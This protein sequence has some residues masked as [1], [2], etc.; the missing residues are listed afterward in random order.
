VGC[1]HA[2]VGADTEGRDTG[3]GESRVLLARLVL[4]LTLALIVAGIVLARLD[5]GVNASTDVGYLLTFSMFP[6]V[7][8]VLSSRRPDNTLGWIMAAIGVSL[9]LDALLST[10]GSY[11]VH[12]GVGGTDLGGAA[13]Q[14]DSVMWVPIVALPATF[15]ILLFP[16][17]H[18]PSPRWRWFA[19]VL[20]VGFALFFVAAIFSPGSL[21]D[22]GYPN[23]QNPLGV[24]AIRSLLDLALV[25]VALIPI[26]V[27]ASLVSLVQRYRRSSGVERLQLRWLVT[28]AT[29][30]GVLYALVLPLSL[31]GGWSSSTTG[32][33]NVFENVAIL[34]FGLIPIAIGVSVLRYRLFE[35][36][37]VVNRALLFAALAV[38]ITAVYLTIVIGV[39]AVVGSR[40]NT[41]LS[42]VA[43][44]VVA[45]AFQPARRR[46][47]RL[48]DR[49]VYGERATP[50]EV[51][52]E[53]S[54]RL[55]N[56]YASDELLPRMA[57]ALAEGTGAGRADVWVRTGGG[58]RSEISWPPDD[59]PA[60]PITTQEA[61]GS[62]TSTSMLEPIRH[63]GELLGAVS[64]R[65]KPGETITATEEKLVRDLATQA[66]LVMRNVSLTEQLL[67]HIEQ[68]R[69]SRQRL[70]AAQDE[71]RRK[72]E[73][74]LHDGAQ[75]QIVAL[76]VKARLLGQ[77]IERD[78][79]QAR[80]MATQLQADATD[81]LEELR[82][83]A[84]GIYPPLL[85]DQG[86]VAAL[87][88]QAR[89]SIAPVTIDADGVGRYP[90][91]TEA[92]VYFSCLEALQ[93]VAKY[94]NASQVTLR[95]FVGDGSLTFEVTD[96]GVGFDA[97]ARSF[98]TGL[99]GIA[100]R[101]AAVGGEI[102]V[103]STPGAGT[104]VT[105]HLPIGDEAAG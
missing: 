92:A 102:Q 93:N 45:L 64:I 41:V 61:E 12:G 49:L 20:A 10:Y 40:S 84:R 104:V 68:L 43:A 5:T 31:A 50:Y 58:F 2:A 94:A 76:T 97:T 56:V 46:A 34:S 15:L 18:L 80:S 78:A 96:D 63:G 105:G 26:G 14:I 33:L 100:D 103:R 89:K 99:Q 24:E 39:G 87:Q 67:D 65:K 6:I 81:A 17:G 57:R 62:V 60:A 72:L 22:S 77:L 1:E 69:A 75:Q 101:L 28:A 86:L 82:D 23:V 4:G 13:L 52:S 54:E 95:L 71:E 38:F 90:R 36:D 32:W 25:F 11:A 35:I 47:Q 83:L 42:A 73:R 48:A 74:N 85:A 53:F 9:G 59:E 27:V 16:T 51:L 98:G 19:R 55:G 21:A 44:A 29:I 3:E 8:Y 91:E 70:V 66:G 7:G 30:V 88:S 79:D 37:V